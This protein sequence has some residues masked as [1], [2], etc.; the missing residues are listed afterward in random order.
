MVPAVLPREV[1]P[2]GGETE[3]AAA[4]HTQALHAAIFLAVGVTVPRAGARTS[5]AARAAGAPPAI[6]FP[7]PARTV[8]AWNE[9]PGVD[10]KPASVRA[11]VY[12]VDEGSLGVRHA[13]YGV[14]ESGELLSGK[15]VV[16]EQASELLV[17]HLELGV[18]LQGGGQHG[19][20]GGDHDGWGGGRHEVPS[21]TR[22]LA[23]PLGAG[24][25]ARYLGAAGDAAP[26]WGASPS[27][28]RAS[29]GATAAG[30]GAA[31]VAGVGGRF[32]FT[33]QTITLLAKW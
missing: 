5:G 3:V 30:T 21:G 15:E 31:A 29:L 25:P 22:L 1:L 8:L 11:E 2:G 14:P 6:L 33:K 4:A 26:W 13:L 24:S 27:P 12:G 7:G 10:V 23:T 32:V 17:G 19:G 9:L 18:P 16:L 20:C 28:L